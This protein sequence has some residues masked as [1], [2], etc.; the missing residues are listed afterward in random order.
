MSVGAESEVARLS[1]GIGN[2][3]ARGVCAP[4]SWPSVDE[5]LVKVV[6]WTRGED[7]VRYPMC[8]GCVVRG[9]GA[10]DSSGLWKL[11]VRQGP[12][13]NYSDDGQ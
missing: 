9:G 11:T 1:D 2:E 5:E 13:N 12:R 10:R 6:E 3:T 7:V 4:S 8:E